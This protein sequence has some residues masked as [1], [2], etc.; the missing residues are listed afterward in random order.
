MSI[1]EKVLYRSTISGK[2]MRCKSLFLF[3]KYMNPQLLL[4]LLSLVFYVKIIQTRHG[5]PDLLP[6]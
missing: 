1:G 5:E 2:M 3:M 6:I 4:I